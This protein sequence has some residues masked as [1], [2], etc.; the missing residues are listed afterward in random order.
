MADPLDD[1]KSNVMS[2]K[3]NGLRHIKWKNIA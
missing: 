2:C 1:R 3:M